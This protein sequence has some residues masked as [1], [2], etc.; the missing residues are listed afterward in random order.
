[1]NIII[2]LFTINFYIYLYGKGYYN[3]GIY[4][5]K[6]GNDYYKGLNFSKYLPWKKVVFGSDR[7]KF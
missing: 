7:N 2:I 6:N 5:N 4:N 1:M 3:T